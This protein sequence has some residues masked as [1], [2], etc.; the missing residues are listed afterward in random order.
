M[1][2][3]QTASSAISPFFSSLASADESSSST[4]SGPKPTLV[5]EA[6]IEFLITEMVDLMFHTTADS[7]NDREAVF[8]KLEMLG[9]QV[10]QGL[11][12]R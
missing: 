5:N 1:S 9:Y 11:V 3:L 7:E 10:G 4:N 6:C 12:E 8:Y 2:V